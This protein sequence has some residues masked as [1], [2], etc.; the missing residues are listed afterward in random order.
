M[1]TPPTVVPLVGKEVLVGRRDEQRDIHPEI[2]LDD[3]GAS[4]RH[5]K[6]VFLADGGIALQ[7]LASTNGTKLNGAEVAA[8][9]RTSLKSGDSV[10]L[11][12]W[13]RITLRGRP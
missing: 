12:R 11:G 10:T 9:S 1:G 4:R 8:G 7:D 6:F 5:A 3:P 2:A 13:T